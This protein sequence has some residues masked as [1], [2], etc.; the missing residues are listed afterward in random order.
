MI[1]CHRRSHD[2]DCVG[3]TQILL[4][5]RRAAAPKGSAQTGHRGAVSYTSLV[6]DAHHAQP[7]REKFLD[8]VVL[9]V[10]QR[11]AS[12]MRHGRSLH[13][14]LTVA[15]FLKGLF[16]RFPN[17]LGD[18][19]HG[20]SRDLPPLAGIGRAVFNRFQSAGMS[21]QLKRVRAF[22]AKCPRE[23]GDSGSPSME[24]SFPFLW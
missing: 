22:W 20:T 14:R 5:C 3:V 11:R 16:A 7:G 23:I 12:K 21:V 1:F 4:C 8:Q 17:A 6:A 2:Q 19:V 15:S 10:V 18:H 13:Q 9:F 24:I